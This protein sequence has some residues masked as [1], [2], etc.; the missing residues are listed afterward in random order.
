MISNGEGQVITSNVVRLNNEELNQGS[1]KEQ[2]SKIL[3]KD[4]VETKDITKI[5]VHL[6]QVVTA[7]A[8]K[9]RES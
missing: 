9:M 3:I 8:K 2:V 6:F 5:I 1:I 4:D 7:Q